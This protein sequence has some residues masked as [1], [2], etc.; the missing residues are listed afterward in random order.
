MKIKALLASILILSVSCVSPWSQWQ[1]A[2]NSVKE[3]KDN[4]ID[5]THHSIIRF[6]INSYIQ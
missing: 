6:S 3:N 2:E 4:I 1:R 5:I